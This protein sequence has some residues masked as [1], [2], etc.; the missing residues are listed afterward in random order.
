MSFESDQYLLLVPD[1]ATQDIIIP[2]LGERLPDY[3]ASAFRRAP[4]CE[5]IIPGVFQGPVLHGHGNFEYGFGYPV[6]F[7][8]EHSLGIPRGL[9]VWVM[10]TLEDN[11]QDPRTRAAVLSLGAAVMDFLP[12][13]PESLV[14]EVPKDIAEMW[15]D[16]SGKLYDASQHAV[17]ML[18][19]WIGVQGDGTRHDTLIK[20][21]PMTQETSEM[22]Y[23]FLTDRGFFPVRKQSK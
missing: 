17:G 16:L 3:W 14:L 23:D 13:T 8:R 7:E 20:F 12:V 21:L 10:E 6:L 9:Y 18:A 5:N 1:A 4:G 22:D 11:P 2:S 19:G 15:P